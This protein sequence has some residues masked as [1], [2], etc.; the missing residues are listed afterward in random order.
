MPNSFSAP[1]ASR[2]VFESTWLDTE[3]AILLGRFA[4][5]SCFNSELKGLQLTRP[6]LRA[7]G[8]AIQS[9]ICSNDCFY[10]LALA[11]QCW[12]GQT[13]T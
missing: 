2:M 8:V 1:A 7:E 12:R 6:S 4:Q 11:R 9:Y 3:K 13:F 5:S 10:C